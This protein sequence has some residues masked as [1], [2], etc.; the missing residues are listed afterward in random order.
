MAGE[1]VRRAFTVFE[2]LVAVVI[3]AVLLA[4]GYSS[5]RTWQERNNV[6]TDTRRIYSELE[7][8]R[9]RALSQK[10]N[11]KVYADGNTLKVVN[12]DNPSDV[13]EVKLHAP[14]EGVIY[15]DNK[16]LM[17]SGGSIFFEGD[18]SL[19]PQVSCVVSDGIRIR[20]GVT[21]IVRGRRQCR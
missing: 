18:L 9:V 15:I 2:L 3:V 17:G 10:L 20:M 6:E 7:Y 19:N 8:Q 11:L 21:R 4:I 1:V 14:F 16:G 12:L 13:R 5:Y